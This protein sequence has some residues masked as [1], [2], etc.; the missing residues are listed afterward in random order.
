MGWPSP[1]SGVDRPWHIWHIQ[2]LEK[3]THLRSTILGGV[4]CYPYTSTHLLG[5]GIWAPKIKTLHTFSGGFWMFRVSLSGGFFFWLN[6]FFWK[7]TFR[8]V[9]LFNKF[10]WCFFCSENFWVNYDDLSRG[11]PKLWFSE[12]LSQNP[13]K[14]SGYGFIMNCHE[15]PRYVQP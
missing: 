6:A 10:Q 4:S 15:L 1:I 13:W 12:E 9:F 2:L 3:Q 7:G 8:H 11:H 14:N 5:F